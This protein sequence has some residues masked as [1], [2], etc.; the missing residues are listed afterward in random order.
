MHTIRIS[1]I[2]VCY[3]AADTIDRTIKS[4]LGQ[5]YE[6]LEYYII[7]GMS[8]DGTR[9]IIQQYRNTGKVNAV[10]EADTGIYNAMNKGIDLCSGAYVLFLNSGD[11]FVDGNVVCNAVKQ[12]CRYNNRKEKMQ[13]GSKSVGIFYGNVI[14]VYETRRFTEK[15]RGKNK[16]FQLLMAGKMPCHQGI[17]TSMSVL[18]EYRFDEAY[19]ICADFDFLVR[20]LR[21]GVSMQYIDIDVSIVDCVRGVSSQSQNLD[22]MREEDDRSLRKNYPIV[23]T[24]MQPLKMV[25]RKY[26]RMMQGCE[27]GHD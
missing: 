3:N 19:E 17:F 27:D 1:V 23:Y 15:Y 10:F 2:T 20:C 22:Q 14:R 13:A 26:R 9:E 12:M 24:I 7:D 21:D 5:T 11:F 8:S 6:N 16:V 25:V 18:K 4:V